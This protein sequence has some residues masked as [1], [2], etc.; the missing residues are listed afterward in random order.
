MV[1]C[2]HSFG[3][4]GPGAADALMRS[5]RKARQ[6]AVAMPA[7][8]PIARCRYLETPGVAAGAAVES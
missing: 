7:I 8:H 4:A 3:P 2:L 1:L 6:Q 5:F